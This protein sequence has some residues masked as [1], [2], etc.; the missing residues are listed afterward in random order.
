MDNSYQHVY[1]SWRLRHYQGI[2]LVRDLRVFT[3]LLIKKKKGI[4]IGNESV[5]E[6]SDEKWEMSKFKS[7]RVTKIVINIDVYLCFI[8]NLDV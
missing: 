1:W 5:V 7:P 6:K 3:T 8:Q 4:F 2:L